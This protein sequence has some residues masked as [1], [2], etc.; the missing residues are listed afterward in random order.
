MS[1]DDP[2]ELERQL[3][4]AEQRLGEARARTALLERRMLR[5]PVDVKLA[6][7]T[8]VIALAGGGAG[9]SIGVARTTMARSED[10]VAMQHMQRELL[11]TRRLAVAHC[12][13][14][15][16]S[17]VRELAVC[18]SRIDVPDPTPEPPRPP[19]PPCGCE[20]GDPLCNCE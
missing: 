5:P 19:P 15:Y 14:S 6:A 11:E 16:E 4:A 12:Q 8:L 9:F 3:S 2:H 18:P 20:M 10:A 1:H 13:R 7:I 17:A